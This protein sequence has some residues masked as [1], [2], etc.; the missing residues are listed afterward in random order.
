MKHLRRSMLYVPGNNPGMVKDAGI[1]GAD[2]V[3]FDLE[4]SVAISEKDAARLLVYEA[5]RAIEYANSQI[6]VRINDLSTDLG[7][8]DL[9][10]IVPLKKAG[11]R[12]PKAETAK[13]I[14]NCSNLIAKLEKDNAIA[15]GSIKMMASIESAKGVLNAKEIAAADPRLVAIAIGAEDYTADIKTNRSREGTELFF[16]RSMILLAARS[17]GIDAIDT[18]FSDINDEEGFKE[19]VRL[20]KQLGFDGK[21]IVNPRQI[22]PIHEI[23]SPTDKE[24]EKALQIMEA[25]EEARRKGSGVIALNG[26]MIDRPVVARAQRILDLAGE[27]RLLE[28]RESNA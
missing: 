27:I 25:F 1:Y 2:C 3:M 13:D 4:D 11:I 26:K 21:S 28:I 23:Y 5:L 6:M 22:R 8:K 17:A 15:P 7:K 18:V 16:A 12:L 19:E 20:I 9:E 10:A 14:T 24:I